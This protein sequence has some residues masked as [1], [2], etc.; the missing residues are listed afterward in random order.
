MDLLVSSF[1]DWMG[2]G[3]SLSEGHVVGVCGRGGPLFP[4]G[5]LDVVTQVAVLEDSSGVVSP[6]SSEG[7]LASRD[8]AVESVNVGVVDHVPGVDRVA[9]TTRGGD[10]SVGNGSDVVLLEPSEGLLTEDEVNGTNDEALGV[11]LVTSLG[12]DG[13]LETP[14]LSG[15]ESDVGSV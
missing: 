12:K 4:S 8:A 1:K 3:N 9:G 7:V 6:W 14:E 13:V 15:V 2:E 5:S 11:E 10:G